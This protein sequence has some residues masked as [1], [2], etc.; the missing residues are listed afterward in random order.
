M[1][2][3]LSFSSRRRPFGKLGE[4][5]NEPPDEIVDS[6]RVKKLLHF[7]IRQR[8][9]KEEKPISRQDDDEYRIERDGGGG[10]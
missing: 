4:K 3:T 9:Q 1:Q 2:S 7:R 5:T 10:G 8:Q 6:V